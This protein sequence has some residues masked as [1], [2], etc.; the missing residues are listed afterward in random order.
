[1]PQEPP[2]LPNASAV[3][4]PRIFVSLD[5][6]PRGRE[7]KVAVVVDI[8]SGFHMN[9][10]KPSEDYLIATT[11]T[12]KLP[13]EFELVDTIYPKGQLE[14][15]SFSPNQP[16]DVYTGSVTFLLK[17][18]AKAAATLGSTEIPMILRYQACN[19]ST[20]LPPVK[21]PLSAKFELAKEG[22]TSREIHSEVFSR[23][24]PA[25]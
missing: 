3:V 12:P 19:D 5:P 23:L 20:C 21:F 10:H 17:L 18:S 4:K 1:M 7:F 11:L 14:K 25:R 9:S 24:L 2:N 22:T 8:A 15:F 13:A 6:V 16:L